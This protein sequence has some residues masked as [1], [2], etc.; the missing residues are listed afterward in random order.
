MND[1]AR[2]DI[3]HRVD[4]LKYVGLIKPDPGTQY[5]EVRCGGRGSG[6]LESMMGEGGWGWGQGVALY[7]TFVTSARLLILQGSSDS[8]IGGCRCM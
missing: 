8:I 6:V 3:G 4:G 7:N 5:L 1:L 2:G